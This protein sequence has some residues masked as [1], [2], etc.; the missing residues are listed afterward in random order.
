[1]D[2]TINK[3]NL[4]RQAFG[5]N[6]HKSVQKIFKDLQKD[7]PHAKVYKETT[8]KTIDIS[9]GDIYQKLSDYV[10]GTGDNVELY[11]HKHTL[12]D[13]FS[14][15]PLTVD[16]CSGINQQKIRLEGVNILIF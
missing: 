6:I 15:N 10:A 1:M 3:S 13:L 5:G 7:I 11:W 14:L 12:K 4:Q 9:A 8:G 16:L 2:L